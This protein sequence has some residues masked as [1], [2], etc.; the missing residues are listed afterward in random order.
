[1]KKIIV[2]LAALIFFSGC[3]IP[4]RTV[5]IRPAQIEIWEERCVIKI[6]NNN[7]KTTHCRWVRV[8]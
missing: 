8:K 7:E 5:G 6:K 1:M 3:Y 2:L 4:A